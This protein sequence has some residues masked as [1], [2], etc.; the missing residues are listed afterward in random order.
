[1]VCSNALWD[2]THTSKSICNAELNA[3]L[4]SNIHIHEQSVVFDRVSLIYDWG[5]VILNHYY[6][7]YYYNIL[8]VILSLLFLSTSSFQFLLYHC[9]NSIVCGI[10]SSLITPW[11]Q[12]GNPINWLLSKR[13]V[14]S[15]H[16]RL[17]V[18]ASAP[19]LIL[20]VMLP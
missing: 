20:T 11:K 10:F 7:Y 9:I 4:L 8:F 2:I 13:M 19:A 12:L 18:P 16:L 17:C 14:G 1:M 5:F 15:L 3:V 6:Y